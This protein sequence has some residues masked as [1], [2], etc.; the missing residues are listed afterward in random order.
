MN[1][2][3]R[4]SLVAL[5]GAAL[6]IAG[7]EP[8]GVTGAQ[9]KVPEP[10]N[11]LLPKEIRIHSF[12]GT[13]VFSEEGGIKGIDV[14][15]EALDA[16]GDATKAFGTFRFELYH[17]KPTSA[18]PKGE[19]MAMWTIDLSDPKQNRESWKGIFRTYQFKLGWSQSIPVGRKFVLVATFDSPF[20]NR[21]PP[22]EH[23]FV[24]GN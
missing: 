24:A 6:G 9:V 10:V 23:V 1:A 12:T 2:I 17:F 14:Q 16:Y 5:A 8:A 18:D 19:R 15:V 21:L 13:R 3:A 11:L 20:T 22:A 7:C 4:L